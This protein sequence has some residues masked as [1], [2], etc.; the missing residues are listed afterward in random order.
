MSENAAWPPMTRDAKSAEF[1]DAAR[2]GELAIKKCTGCGLSLAPEAMV[3]TDCGGSDPV[4][5]SAS[6]AGALVTWTTVH[7]APNRAFTDLVPYTVGIVEL[8]EGPWLYAGILGE[9]GAG[10]ALR[11][12]FVHP[13]EGESYPV[14]VVENGDPA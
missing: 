13:P 14:W 2:R 5:A 9:P 10:A 4:W 1:F 11:V 8:A 7:K 12:E 6:G 3:C